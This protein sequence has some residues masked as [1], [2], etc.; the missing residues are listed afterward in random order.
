MERKNHQIRIIYV[1]WLILRDT[2]NI[3]SQHSKLIKSIIKALYA[4]A[5]TKTFSEAIKSVLIKLCVCKI[6]KINDRC[7]HQP[8]P[9][10]LIHLAAGRRERWKLTQPKN[11]R[12]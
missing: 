12:P 5:R 4:R 1:T 9:R 10:I 2:I 8:A 6:L 3:K 11:R 7:T